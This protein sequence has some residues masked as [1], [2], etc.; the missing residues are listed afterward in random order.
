MVKRA[1]ERINPTQNFRRRVPGE[2]R[3]ENA[4]EGDT[5]SKHPDP[6]ADH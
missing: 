6:K 4:A 2:G 5:L 3:V 1:T